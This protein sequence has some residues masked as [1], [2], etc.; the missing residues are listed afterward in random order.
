MIKNILNKIPEHIFEGISK[1]DFLDYIENVFIKIENLDRIH[2]PAAVS[3][4]KF[5]FT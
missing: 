4:L 1:R 2:I 5:K 3:F